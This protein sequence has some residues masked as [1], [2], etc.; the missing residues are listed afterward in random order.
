MDV[1]VIGRGLTAGLPI[2]IVLQRCNATITNCHSKTINIKEKAQKAQIFISAIGKSNYF[3]REFISDDAIVIDIGINY[4][5][6]MNGTRTITGDVDFEDCLI[7]SSFITPVPGGAG[8]MTVIMIIKNLLK[9]WC[10]DNNI[11]LNKF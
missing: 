4:I 8:R 10:M 9:A 2:S 5:E 3:K 1:C 6:N 11:D 7:K